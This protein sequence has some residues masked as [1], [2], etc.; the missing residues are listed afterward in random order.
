MV[1][2]SITAEAHAAIRSTLPKGVR[3]EPQLDEGGGFKITLDRHTLDR[4]TAL[5][6]PGESTA[7]S[8]CGWRLAAAGEPRWPIEGRRREAAR[9][10]AAGRQKGRLRPLGFFKCSR[11]KVSLSITS[12][13][14]PSIF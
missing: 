3:A 6:G 11:S 14:G 2:I 13:F 7:T 8:F 12:P 10:G 9:S 1:T 5:R 4:L